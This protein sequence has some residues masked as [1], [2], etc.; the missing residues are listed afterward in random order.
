LSSC[1]YLEMIEAWVDS[2]IVYIDELEQDIPDILAPFPN[3]T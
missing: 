2:Q 3:R 1:T